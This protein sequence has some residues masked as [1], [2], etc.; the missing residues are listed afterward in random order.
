MGRHRWLHATARDGTA[1]PLRRTPRFRIALGAAFV[2]LGLCLGYGI[3]SVATADLNRSAAP[4]VAGIPLK[5]GPS[6]GPTAGDG[7]GEG[8]AGTDGEGSGE[9][10]GGAGSGK[11]AGGTDGGDGA[12]PG[13]DGGADNGDDAGARLIIHVAGAVASP[14]IVRL[15]EGA[16]VFEAI[17]AAGGAKTGAQLEALNLAAPL[18]DGQQVY[19]PTREDAGPPPVPG[20]GSADGSV[21]GPGTGGGAANG[22]VGKININTATV[23]ELAELPRVGP[24]LAGRIV[25]FREQHGPYGQPSD[26]DAVPGI[27]PVMLEAL[28]ELVTV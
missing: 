23:E 26:L 7:S 21:G 6:S 17:E 4:V 8:P 18:T 25:E 9:S 3:V 10:L 14:G 27:G 5:S 24:V 16:R 22:P 28:V 15:V 13:A 19:V 11:D 2:V 12:G 1:P 20:T